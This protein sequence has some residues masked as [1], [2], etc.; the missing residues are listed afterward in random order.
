MIFRN[1][2]GKLINIKK[3]DYTNDK[4]F[5]KKII[6]AKFNVSKSEEKPN[7]SSEI[8]RNFLK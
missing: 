3:Y 4:A 1:S 2:Q 5:Y 7:Y 6:D 8:I